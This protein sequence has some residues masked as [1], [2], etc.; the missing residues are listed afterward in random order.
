MSERTSY[1][2]G[3]PC[4]VELAAPP[5]SRPR[6]SFYGDAVRLGGPGAAELGRDWAATARRSWTASRRRR[7]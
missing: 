6:R 7:R 2:P 1:E 4:W 5:T 3:T